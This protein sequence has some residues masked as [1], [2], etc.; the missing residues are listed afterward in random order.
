MHDDLWVHIL[1]RL[2][3]YKSMSTKR[4]EHNT[5]TEN[6]YLDPIDPELTGLGSFMSAH[7]PDMEVVDLEWS[8]G[9]ASSHSNSFNRR[10]WN[11]QSKH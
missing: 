7:L 11:T 8:G 1:Q 5:N 3:Q 2:S 9:S 4:S 6:I 10:A